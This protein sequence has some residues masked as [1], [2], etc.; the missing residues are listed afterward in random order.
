MNEGPIDLKTSK[1]LEADATLFEF[2]CFLVSYSGVARS[3]LDIHYFAW[4]LCCG[5]FLK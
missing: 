3:T 2:I 4:G 5:R 1:H